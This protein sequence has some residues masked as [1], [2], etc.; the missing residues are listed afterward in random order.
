[1]ATSRSSRS[2]RARTSESAWNGLADERKNVTSP[3]SPARRH[4]LAVPHRDRVHAVD[5]L[6]GPAAADGYADRLH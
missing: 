1:M 4:D 5:R 6:D 2:G 3:G